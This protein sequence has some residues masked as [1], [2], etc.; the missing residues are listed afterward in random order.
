MNPEQGLQVQDLAGAL[1][2]RQGVMSVIAGAIFLL[3]IVVA[4]VLPNEYEAW[5]TLLV[6]PQ[7]IS[8][9]LVE[10]GLEGAELESRLHLMTMQILSRGR[11]S[12]VITDLDL[13]PDESKEMT[14]AIGARSMTDVTRF[15]PGMLAGISGRLVAR[16]GLMS[17][18]NP[19]AHAVVSNVPGPQVP[20]YFT[21]ARM[22]A[23]FG[24]GLPLDGMGLFH[25]VMSYNGSITISVTS[26]RTLLPDPA[27]YAEC[28]EASFRELREAA[29]T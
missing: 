10:A 20:L 9:R 3:S 11:L 4:A 28:L 2:R 23:G 19:V 25:A 6:E 14:R 18:M 24:M 5:T 16:T 12:R 17:R 8:P 13:Y 21:G 27:F 1:R 7:S 26:C 22:V 15:M 29:V